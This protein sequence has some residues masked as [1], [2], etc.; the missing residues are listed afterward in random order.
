MSTNADGA[1]QALAP[2]KVNLFLH[3]GPVRPD[4][5]H[6]VASWMVFADIG[7]SLSLSPAPS[8]TFQLQGETA[9][10]VNPG[11]NLVERAARLLF[12][13][14]GVGP[15]PVRLTLHKTLPVAAGLGG[16]SS[17]A[18][19]AL[20]LLNARLPQPLAPEALEAVAARLGADGPACLRA[21]SVLAVG[22]GEVLSKPPWCPPLPAVLVN[23]GRPSPTAAVYRAYDAGPPA[24]SDLPR[25]PNSLEGPQ[26]V[27]ALL[28]KTRNDLRGPAVQLEPTIAEV[29]DVLSPEPETLLAR[30][31]GSGATC[32]ALCATRGDAQALAARL[33]AA[34]PGWWV[35]ACSLGSTAD[36]SITN[37]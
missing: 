11:E 4:G 33:S 29:L 3:V 12:D 17:D 35:R 2:A 36:T 19:A 20:R 24:G 31:S 32:F 5:Y 21:R 30:M 28:E 9:P 23:P 22:V 8:W 27:A 15:L 7:D 1:G 13:A 26:E 14:A 16:G 6:P 10:A 25:L 34:H 18:G 37:T